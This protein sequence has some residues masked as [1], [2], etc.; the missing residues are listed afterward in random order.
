MD[1]AVEPRTA[2]AMSLHQLTQLAPEN[3]KYAEALARCVSRLPDVH[4]QVW[5]G[6]GMQPARLADWCRMQ[7][8]MEE[9][10]EGLCRRIQQE[11][12]AQLPE[13]Q[14]ARPKYAAYFAWMTQ[15]IK[16]RHPDMEQ[17]SVDKLLCMD[18]GE[19]DLL[20]QPQN[21]AMDAAMLLAAAERGIDWKTFQALASTG[22][23]RMIDQ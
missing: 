8:L 23:T 19:L 3:A 10:T 22:A 16:A 17:S 2:A 20:L 4:G 9:S 5:L 11:R 7:I 12:D 6:G 13:F 18:S 1:M 14:R 21:K 15:R